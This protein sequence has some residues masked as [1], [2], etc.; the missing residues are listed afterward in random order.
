MVMKRMI[1]GL[2][3]S[4]LVGCAGKPSTSI[5]VSRFEPSTGNVTIEHV[6]PEL[7][8]SLKE[9]GKLVITGKTA[10]GQLT[11]I[12]GFMGEEKTGFRPN[13]TVVVVIDPKGAINVKSVAN[14]KG[15]ARVLTD[16]LLAIVGSGVHGALGQALRR[17]DRITISSTGG[18]STATGGSSAASSE[19]QA[20]TAGNFSNIDQQQ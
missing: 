19:S 9:E 12:L 2:V 4:L 6:S 3:V 15:E 5:I 11:G 7:L 10:D 20:A 8:K 18:S 16:S 13:S 17:P 14:D 1:V